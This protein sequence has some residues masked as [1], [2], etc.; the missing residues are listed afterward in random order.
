MRGAAEME[1]LGRRPAMTLL[2]RFGHVKR[3]IGIDDAC[4]MRETME[5]ARELLGIAHWTDERALPEQVCDV[6][7]VQ[8]LQYFIGERWIRCC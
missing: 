5:Q 6:E 7:D 1:R 4:N 2:E 3:E 8:Y